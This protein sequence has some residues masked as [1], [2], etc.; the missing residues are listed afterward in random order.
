MVV[1]SKDK[2]QQM[3]FCNMHC[4]DTYMKGLTNRELKKLR[5]KTTKNFFDMVVD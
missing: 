2:E 4:L 3:D 1:F 5:K